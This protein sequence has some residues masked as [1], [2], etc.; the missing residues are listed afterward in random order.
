MPTCGR[1]AREA[2]KSWLDVRVQAIIDGK[3]YDADRRLVSY[4]LKNIGLGENS[5][6]IDIVFE[7]FHN[8]LAANQ[9]GNMVYET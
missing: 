6:R 1:R 7:C 3:T 2:L 4:W 5:R 9:R 8:F